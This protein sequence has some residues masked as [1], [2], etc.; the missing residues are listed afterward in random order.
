ME[1]KCL[2][3]V[4]EHK[5]FLAQQALAKVAEGSPPP[6]IEDAITLVP[7]WQQQMIGGQI[8]LSCVAIPA[9]MRHIEVHEQTPEEK[10]V[11]GGRLLQAR[12]EMR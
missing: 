7:T 8:I 11:A 12:A 6:L 2:Q 10:A 9:C 1:L 3:C 5:N 4:G